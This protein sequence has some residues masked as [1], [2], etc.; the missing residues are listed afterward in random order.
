MPL[1]QI[2]SHTVKCSTSDKGSGPHNLGRNLY[3]AE[4]SWEKEWDR[5]R[6]FNLGDIM[7]KDHRLGNKLWQESE[8]SELPSS[9]S[10]LK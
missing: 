3:K 2:K 4:K 5:A 10:F 9:Y 1:T 7:S 8:K 6:L